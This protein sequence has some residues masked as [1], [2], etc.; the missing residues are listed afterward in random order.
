MGKA[1]EVR[2][3]DR[4]RQV[5]G[6]PLRQVGAPVGQGTTGVAS[7]TNETEAVNPGE[8]VIDEETAQTG[9]SLND[10]TAIGPDATVDWMK[11]AKTRRGTVHGK[12]PVGWARSSGP[13]WPPGETGSTGAKVLLRPPGR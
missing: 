7:V 12:L 8:G 10:A 1:H 6:D 4:R 5:R 2:T 11:D 13:H 9:D 3:G